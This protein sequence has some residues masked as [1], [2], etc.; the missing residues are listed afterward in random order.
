MR[1]IIRDQKALLAVS[2]VALSAYARTAGWRKLEPYGDHSDVYIGEGL[3]EIILP[4]TQRL[5]DYPN[6]I[7]HLIEIFARAAE[8]D[9]LALYRDLVTADRDVIRVWVAESEDGSVTASDGIRLV[10]GAHDMLLA[11]ACS[12]REPQPLY[13]AG[14]NREA[15]DYLN[16]V[17]LG[18]T[19]Q[20]SFAVT[21]LTPAIPPRIQQVLSPE[22]A[23]DDVPIERRM[24]KRLA[25][26]LRATRQATEKVVGGDTDAFPQAVEY[27]ASANLCDALVRLIEPFPALDVSLTWAR[28]HPTNTARDVVR[29][30]KSDASILREAARLFRDRGPRPDVRFV[31]FVHRLKRDEWEMEGTITLRAYIDERMQSVVAV[32][33]QSD[34]RRAVQAHQEKALVSMEGDLERVGQRWHLLNPR[35]LNVILDEDASNEDE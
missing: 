9:E 27:G 23:P 13:R 29:F 3:P 12:L 6:V 4:L 1:A 30:A 26:A 15:T 35:I 25:S 5:G 19:E 21:L 33:S 16:R 22:L 32:L 8:M 20:S 17:R 34:Y 7:S 18:Q 11:A 31:G 10:T 28:T 14:A 24:T 2:P